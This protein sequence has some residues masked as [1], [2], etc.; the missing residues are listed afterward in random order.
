MIEQ[1][2]VKLLRECDAGI[3]MGV[4]SIN[5]VLPH[6]QSKDLKNIL[7]ECKRRHET[8][9]EELQQRLDRFGDEG[10]E[11]NPIAKGMSWMK[12]NMKMN[13]QESDATIAD[14]MTDGCNMGVKSLSKYLNQYKAAEEYSKDIAKK[15]IHLEAQLAQDIRGYL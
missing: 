3:K 5:D 2:T 8:L 13:L 9:K 12:T 4:S 1:D 10:K 14:L 6:V 15:L 7:T 11:P